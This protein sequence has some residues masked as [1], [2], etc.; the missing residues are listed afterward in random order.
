MQPNGGKNRMETKRIL[1]TGAAGFLG[2]HVIERLESEGHEVVGFDITEP[3]PA[4]S[5]FVRGDFT[6]RAQFQA[7]LKGIN[8]VCHLGGVGDVYLADRDPAL[9]FRVN[10]YGTLVVCKCCAASQI[11]RMVSASTWEV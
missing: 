7:A 2:H 6:S 11:E 3:T 10:A 9:A 8:A 1:V 4:V 5:S